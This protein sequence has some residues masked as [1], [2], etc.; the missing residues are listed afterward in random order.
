VGTV[1]VKFS[2]LSRPVVAQAASARQSPA[3]RIGVFMAISSG[4]C[5]HH[6]LATRRGQIQQPAGREQAQGFR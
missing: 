1:Q 3:I 6:A 5:R 2:A 4:N